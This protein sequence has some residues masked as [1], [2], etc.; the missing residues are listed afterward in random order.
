M[1]ERNIWDQEDAQELLVE[2]NLET[3]CS[4]L[5]SYLYAGVKV[6]DVGCGPGPVT[7]DVASEIHPGS[8]V[9]IDL[10]KTNI[11]QAKE[12]AKTSQTDNAVFQVGDA[13]ALEFADGTFD[14][15]YSLNLLVWLRDP[16]RTLQE[17]KRVTQ[18]GGWVIALLS[19]YANIISY[20]TCPAFDSFLAALPELAD[21]SDKE[22][23]ID[24][25]QGR[26]AVELFTQAGLKELK[27]E[28]WVTCSYPGSKDFDRV[29]SRWSTVLGEESPFEPY[30]QKLIDLGVIDK[31]TFLD[32][33]K[34][35][36]AWHAHPHAFHT[37]GQLVVAGRVP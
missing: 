5:K 20:P 3:I 10:E 34:E 1:S 12:L 32:A 18:R 37:S 4:P 8:V 23:F 13:Y 30:K 14:L 33:Q 29:Y 16:V 19:D 25:H 9:G 11:D 21:P 7:M 22:I 6:L 27:I 31:E 28:G 36:E 2:R 17:Q 15:T 26:R 35:L 24:P